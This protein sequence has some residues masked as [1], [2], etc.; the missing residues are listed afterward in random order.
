MNAEYRNGNLNDWLTNGRAVHYLGNVI[1]V[2]GGVEGLKLFP[3]GSC[4]SLPH[5]KVRL[6]SDGIID[7]LLP[8]SL[9]PSRDQSAFHR[10]IP[11]LPWP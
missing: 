1:S 11:G 2:Y 5:V 9:H 3:P 6:C 4:V 10:S 7:K 8:Y